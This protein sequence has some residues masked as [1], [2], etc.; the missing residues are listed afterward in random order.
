MNLEKIAEEIKL[1][2][3]DK[4]M[5]YIDGEDSVTHRWCKQIIWRVLKKQMPETEQVIS[6]L[7]TILEKYCY[8]NEYSK[9]EEQLEKAV[10]LLE[11]EVIQ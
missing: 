2:L 4:H 7:K 8:Q 10:S 3:H 6:I 1:E 5:M 11:S 9:L